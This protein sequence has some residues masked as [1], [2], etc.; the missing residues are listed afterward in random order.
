M[1]REKSLPPNQRLAAQGKWPLVGEKAARPLTGGEPWRI[2][3][4][5]L[6]ATPQTWTLEEVK[7]MPRVERVVD[8]HC[9]T[10]WSKLGARFSGVP[11]KLLLDKCSSLPSARYLSFVARSTR[12]HS[13]SLPLEDALSLDAL[14]ALEYEGE[15]LEEEHGGPVRVIVPGRYFYKSVKWLE[16]I[17]VLAEDRLGYWEKEAGY[18]NEADPWLEQ[19]YIA[20]SVDRRTLFE[21][22]ASKDF[23]GKDFLSLDAKGLELAGLNAQ[24]ALLRNADFRGVNLERAR[25]Q[26]ANLSNAHFEGAR[27]R[28]ASFAGADVEGADFRRADLRGADFTGASMFGTTFCDEPDASSPALIDHTTTIDEESISKLLPPQQAFV[29]AALRP[30]S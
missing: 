11:L 10:R 9:V 20:P 22:L 3:V 16:R 26:S 30:K 28:S 21:A 17:E 4:E 2:S 7:E 24:A 1:E 6:V 5:G 29:R 25:F 8:I 15:P 19:R 12:S 14:V 13:T 27:L 23:R 18:H